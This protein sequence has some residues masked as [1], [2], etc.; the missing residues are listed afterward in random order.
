[1]ESIIRIGF[2]IGLTLSSVFEQVELKSVTFI[3]SI[4]YLFLY[5][6]VKDYINKLFF[7]FLDVGVLIYFIY[8]TGNPY[9]SLFYLTLLPVYFQNKINF[10]SYIL[11][12]IFLVIFSYYLTN[13]IDFTLIS[14]IT[15]SYISFFAILKKIK[16]YNDEINHLKNNLI[17]LTTKFIDNYNKAKSYDLSEFS[18]ISLKDDKKAIFELFSKLNTTGISLFDIE[19]NKCVSIAKGSCDK[20]LLNYIENK[21]YSFKYEGDYVIIV[22][23]YKNDEISKVMFFF[24]SS[25]RLFDNFN[26]F[27]YLKVKFENEL[28]S[29]FKS[30]S[31]LV[32]GVDEEIF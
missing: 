2:I 31:K 28:L 13:Y 9:I 23:L 30:E 4:L 20:K 11:L 18:K 6:F 7:L 22:P 5:F 19:N 12:I 29:G 3:L 21:I 16:E 15:V 17:S 32:K 24:Y 8:L 1:M 10:F 25:E 27:Y 14:I 26:I